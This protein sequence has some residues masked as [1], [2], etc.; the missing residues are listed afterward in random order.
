[1]VTVPLG[2][3]RLASTV[4]I[5]KSVWIR[6]STGLTSGFS[7]G[8]VISPDPGITASSAGAGD[9]AIISNLTIHNPN[10]KMPNW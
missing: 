4:S 9:G 1:M 7:A 8:C 10:H 2:I 3:F 5:K 6:G